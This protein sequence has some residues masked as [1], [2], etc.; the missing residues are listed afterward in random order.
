MPLNPRWG[1]PRGGLLD[2]IVKSFVSTLKGNSKN[3]AYLANW[4]GISQGAI[5]KLLN[6]HS[7]LLIFL[8][9]FPPEVLN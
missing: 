3:A 4:K 9:E 6:L 2:A 8:N 1:V 7:Q 5:D